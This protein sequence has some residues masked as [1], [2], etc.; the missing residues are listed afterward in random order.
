MIKS[1]FNQ[2]CLLFSHFPPHNHPQSITECTSIGRKNRCRIRWDRPA[3]C[4]ACTIMRDTA[5]R[6]VAVQQYS[7]VKE[8]VRTDTSLKARVHA[9]MKVLYPSSTGGPSL[10]CSRGDVVQ[11]ISYI[12]FFF[13]HVSQ[14]Y[15]CSAQARDDFTYRSP[16]S[17]TRGKKVE[18][19]PSPNPYSEY[20]VHCRANARAH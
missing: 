20:T 7:G 19:G 12:F 5:S 18:P 8:D 10:P 14:Q 16:S 11:F 17:Q 15:S 13:P 1:R 4:L 3:I 2:S 6:C 9:T